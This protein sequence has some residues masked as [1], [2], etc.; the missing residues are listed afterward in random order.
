[1]SGIVFSILGQLTIANWASISFPRKI[2]F[3]KMQG[4][5]NSGMSVLILFAVQLVFGGV[6]TAILF[7]GRW[8]GSPWLPAEVFAVLAFAALS[9]YFAALKGFTELAEAKKEVLIDALCR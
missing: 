4:Q 6:S 8:T 7:S 9:G 5:R 2:E 1:L 3:G